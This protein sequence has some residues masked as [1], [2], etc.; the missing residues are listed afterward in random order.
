MHRHPQM[1][2]QNRSKSL[3]DLPNEIILE[4]LELVVFEHREHMTDDMESYDVGL[5]TVHS[6]SRVSRRLRQ[7]THSQPQL[8][9][10]LSNILH[11]AFLQFCFELSGNEDLQL[12]F[13]GYHKN[14]GEEHPEGPLPDVLLTSVCSNRWKTVDLIIHDPSE[15]PSYMLE[16]GTV[17]PFT[18]LYELQ[19]DSPDA[20]GEG[21]SASE[22][23]G[24]FAQLSSL[25]MFGVEHPATKNSK[26]IEPWMT[27]PY[28]HVPHLTS[29]QTNVMNAEVAGIVAPALTRLSF[30][31]DY[32]SP[33]T[34]IHKI[35]ESMPNLTTLSFLISNKAGMGT[36]SYWINGDAPSFATLSSLE[37]TFLFVEDCGHS[38]PKNFERSIGGI[39]FA[40]FPALQTLSVVVD[41]NSN[42]DAIFVADAMMN[43][44]FS[45]EDLESV[46]EKPYIWSSISSL[47]ITTRGGKSVMLPSSGNVCR[48]LFAIP[49]N[50]LHNLRHLWCSTSMLR[51]FDGEPPPA[52]TPYQYPALQSVELTNCTAVS[53]ESIRL[54]VTG[55]KAC[56]R[57]NTLESFVMKDCKFL[58]HKSLDFLD[59]EDF[60]RVNI[61]FSEGK[62][63]SCTSAVFSL[64]L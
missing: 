58:N 28:W 21:S 24:R 19:V 46:G 36:L 16:T 4:C 48:G 47:S 49:F 38:V 60:S 26:S 45:D 44:L 20:A 31:V 22:V 50:H 51:L 40:S 53:P 18:V 17:K 42:L 29:F 62:A 7:L 59:E 6:V 57:W 63:W 14:D 34:S 64:S 3:N 35:V 43:F 41:V 39:R 32:G 5:K 52:T 9:S 25:R 30:V 61:S 13:H 27:Y 37:L 1:P 15:T 55:M 56:N 10:V 8:W 12:T 33:L 54:F 23:P 2:F 11:P